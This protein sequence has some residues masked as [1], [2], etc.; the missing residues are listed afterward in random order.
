VDRPV[1]SRCKDFP[2]A[3]GKRTYQD[4][5]APLNPL[6]TFRTRQQNPSTRMMMKEPK[7]ST[8]AM[9]GGEITSTKLC[10]VAACLTVMLALPFILWEAQRDKELHI[11]NTDTTLTHISDLAHLIAPPGATVLSSTRNRSSEKRSR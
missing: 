4:Q 6:Y 11:I 7:E 10:L 1:R 5:V 2:R 3:P 8:R 9:K